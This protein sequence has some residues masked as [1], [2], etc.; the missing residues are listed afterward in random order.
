MI[1]SLSQ[2]LLTIGAIL[3]IIGAARIYYLWSNG[4]QD[5]DREIILWVGGI[6]FLMLIP[7]TV[8]L[9]T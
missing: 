1:D 5:I 9:M 4:K 6:L 8:K 3:S 2:L 7:V